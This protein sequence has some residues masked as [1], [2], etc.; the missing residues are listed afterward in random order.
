MLE[1][2]QNAKER[3]G[4]VSKMVDR[5]LQERQDMLVKY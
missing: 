3:W 5:L 1:N 4:G 2:C